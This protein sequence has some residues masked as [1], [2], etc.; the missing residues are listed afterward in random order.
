[1]P[2]NLWAIKKTKADQPAL[3]KEK[4]EIMKNTNMK[5]LEK[6]YRE[7]MTTRLTGYAGALAYYIRTE[8]DK[9]WSTAYHTGDYSHCEELFTELLAK[10]ATA[11]VSEEKSQLMIQE[12]YER[13]EPH[14][15]MY[16]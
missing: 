12:Y 6:Q 9:E 7:I 3:S 10:M 2:A 16:T 13:N 11:M 8:A 4:E 14:I 1:M 5:K 15:Y